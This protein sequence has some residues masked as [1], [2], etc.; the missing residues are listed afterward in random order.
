MSS[1]IEAF[2]TNSGPAHFARLFANG[3]QVGGNIATTF[4]GSGSY[5]YYFDVPAATVAGHYSYA[6]YRSGNG[7]LRS[8]GEFYWDGTDL[9]FTEENELN[10]TQVEAATTAALTAYDPPTQTE[11]VALQSALAALIGAL[12]TTAQIEAALLNDGD[13]QA[14][15]AAIS[16]NV[17][18]AFNNETDGSPTLA[19][20]QGVVSSAL[21]AYG[22]ATSANVLAS[23]GLL[24]AQM[25][26]LTLIRDI[27]E[28]DEVYTP[29][30]AQKRLKGTATVLVDKVVTSDTECT[31]N[32]SLIGA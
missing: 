17:E 12:P 14:L 15:L 23:S 9:V 2:S 25:I 10:V 18:A 26:M 8:I 11:M 30:S 13:G 4:M 5:G 27:L 31:V 28:A 6:L 19:G 20:I 7:R 32:T 3:T 1:R 21:S 24:P 29:T 16:A 22:A